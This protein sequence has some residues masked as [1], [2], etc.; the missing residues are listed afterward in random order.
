MNLISVQKKK[1]R[2]IKYQYFRSA[3]FFAASSGS[4][5]TIETLVNLSLQQGREKNKEEGK[6]LAELLSEK[7]NSGKNKK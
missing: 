7:D 1:Y 3:I 2:E 5:D 6:V 4:L